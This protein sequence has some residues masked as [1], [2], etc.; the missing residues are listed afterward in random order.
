MVTL[1][2]IKEFLEIKIDE[3]LTKEN[4]AWPSVMKAVV[5]HM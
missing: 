5:E 3:N 2:K 4:N 1:E